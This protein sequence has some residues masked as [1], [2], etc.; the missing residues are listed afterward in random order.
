M[1]PTAVANRLQDE[2]NPSTET[3][4]D[5]S[6]FA[7]ADSQP[8]AA[9]PPVI[10]HPPAARQGDELNRRLCAGAYCY[11]WFRNYV[12]QTVLE[13]TYRALGP[14]G[15]IDLENL[16]AHCLKARA[17]KRKCNVT[18]A[19]LAIAQL[20]IFL[21][22]ALTVGAGFGL[23]LFFAGF[24]A[25]VWIYF[26]YLWTTEVEIV[27]RQLSKA[28][29]NRDY[30]GQKLSHYEKQKVQEA[31]ASQEGHVVIYGG[32]SPFV[33]SGNDHGGWS[34]AI[35]LKPGTDPSGRPNATLPF[36][37]EEL[38]QTMEATVRA[39]GIPG[40]SVEDKLYVHG[41]DLCLI[42][43]FSG[44]TE[45]PQLNLDAA[46]FDRL[47]LAGNDPVMRYYKG[48]KFTSWQ[49]E[50]AF[51]TFV[52][53]H[54]SPGTLF[55]EATY[56]LL[57]PLSDSF[58]RFDALLPNPSGQ[59]KFAL[60]IRAVSRAVIMQGFWYLVLLGWLTEWSQRNAVRKQER[61]QLR[62]I[63]NFNRGALKTIRECAMSQ[64]YRRYF[65]KQ[66][67]EF[68]HKILEKTLLDGIVSFL[69]RH[70]YDTGDLRERQNM[71]LNN[72][73]IVSGGNLN[74][75]S[76]TVGQ[77]ARTFMGKVLNPAGQPAPGRKQR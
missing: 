5:G 31:V 33:G 47:R 26:K 63:Y 22:A 28:S 19:A 3:V 45:R 39:L 20:P 48:F 21:I 44:G 61:H 70:G 6:R 1:S 16:A 35:N 36:A 17:L 60:F 74:A 18:M 42:E 73:V 30:Q 66:D 49:G 62:E 56:H 72:G 40:F 54:L 24:V 27:A 38:Y 9:A 13:D 51:S 76:L 7:N 15:E 55:I 8:A 75:E 46:A 64:N 37:A 68:V 32:F 67:K 23:F 57:P 4:R 65:Q 43:G 69:E 25:Q 71:I 34:F 2:A 41:G 53:F 29:F 58:Y 10:S 14:S 50:V 12:I 59:T 11:D 77:R 52:R